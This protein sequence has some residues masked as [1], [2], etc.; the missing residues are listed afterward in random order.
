M[1]ENTFTK[2]QAH[3]ETKWDIPKISLSCLW[4]S[5]VFFFCLFLFFNSNSFIFFSIKELG[6]TRSGLRGKKKKTFNKTDILRELNDS[7]SKG[8][9]WRKAGRGGKKVRWGRG[10][11]RKEKKKQ[12]KRK[13]RIS[14]T[15]AGW[16]KKKKKYVREEEEHYEVIV[17][18]F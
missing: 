11:K 4:D 7:Q 12:V 13:K 14:K 1:N 15:K 8:G 17:C 9:Q 2:T 16:G 3:G 5:N 6:I 18:K 10:R